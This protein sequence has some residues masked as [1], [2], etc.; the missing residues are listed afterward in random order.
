M[1]DCLVYVI[2]WIILMLLGIIEFWLQQWL[3][4]HV[5][6]YIKHAV[7][8]LFLLKNLEIPSRSIMLT[9]YAKMWQ[10]FAS[11]S[12]HNKKCCLHYVYGVYFLMVSWTCLINCIKSSWCCFSSCR[13]CCSSCPSPC[14][15]PASD[16]VPR[17]WLYWVN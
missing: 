4:K 8:L 5:P 11:I 17:S 16:F 7:S 2:S 10:H 3:H 13:C 14:Q 1:V 9:T 12:S 15:K 6:C